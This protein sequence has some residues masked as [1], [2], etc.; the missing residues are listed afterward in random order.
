MKCKKKNPRFLKNLKKSEKAFR[1]RKLPTPPP[2][3]QTF[4]LINSHVQPNNQFSVKN[5]L[6]KHS[7]DRLRSSPP[8]ER[9]PGQLPGKRLRCCLNRTVLLLYHRTLNADF[10]PPEKNSIQVDVQVIAFA[11]RIYGGDCGPVVSSIQTMV[12]TGR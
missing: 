3:E 7:L 5:N 9:Y 2:T 1:S 8:F 12:T 6:P 11:C 4:F 10:P